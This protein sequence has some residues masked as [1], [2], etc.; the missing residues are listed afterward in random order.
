MCSGSV[1]LLWYSL[2]LNRQ[3]SK[4][5]AWF[6]HTP[7]YLLCCFHFR[8]AQ[9]G[10][11]PLSVMPSSSSCCTHTCMC[12]VQW[13]PVVVLLMYSP[14]KCVQIIL[15]NNFLFPVSDSGTSCPLSHVDSDSKN[16]SD[17]TLWNE[18]TFPQYICDLYLFISAQNVHPCVVS[19]WMT[20]I[21]KVH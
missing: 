11:R 16:T 2:C 12:Q 4:R 5:S 17:V 10:V 19:N 13:V 18:G 15:A 1:V 14:A 3:W 8:T 21:L 9:S 20:K 7:A 6:K